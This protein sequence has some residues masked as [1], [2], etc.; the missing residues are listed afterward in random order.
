[1]ANI[2]ATTLPRHLSLISCEIISWSL[3]R[4]RRTKAP[5]Y[6]TSINTTAM[7]FFGFHTEIRLKIYSEL[8]RSEPIVFIAGYGPLSPPLFWSKRDNLS[9]CPALLRVNKKMYSEVSP[10]LYSKN[11]FR[12]PDIFTSTVLT[13]SHS[14]LRSD[15]KQPLFA[16]STSPSLPLTI[17]G[18]VELGFMKHILKI[19]NSSKIPVQA[20]LLLNCRSA[21]L[22]H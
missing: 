21:T 17:T 8:V 7:N 20:S 19:W 2:G 16:T 5:K 6:T 22:F 11:S 10:L 3:Q 13:S 12:F 9:L 14:L 1:M 15:L 18:V 4:R